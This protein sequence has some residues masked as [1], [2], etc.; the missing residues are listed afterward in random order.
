[1][2]HRTA[3]AISGICSALVV[4]L[5]GS[6]MADITGAGAVLDLT[7]EA[8]SINGG[9]N[10]LNLI[11]N[12]QTPKGTGP[13]NTFPTLIGTNTLGR[14]VIA[15][16]YEQD[17]T[18]GGDG[19]LVVIRMRTE[20]E[21]PLVPAGQLVLGRAASHFS[22]RV[23][24]SEN[25]GLPFESW[26]DRVR[27]TG[28]SMSATN[29]TQTLFR[30]A[31]DDPNDVIKGQAQATI[32]TI[33]DWDGLMTGGF[34]SGVFGDPFFVGSIGGLGDW[35]SMTVVFEVEAIPAPAS[36]ACLGLAGL[37][38]TRRRR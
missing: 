20:D 33:E 11:N 21:S 7:V 10:T 28:F 32:D 23:G 14:E 6:A 15:E 13:D 5:A 16:W 4:S 35:Y 38:A 24:S 37:V 12:G 31:T 30:R 9:A 26:V 3:S 25:G 22:I 1:M 2:G 36:A 27:L 19:S 29:G 34:W 8:F 17:R 18:D